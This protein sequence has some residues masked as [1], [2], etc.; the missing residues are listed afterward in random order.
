VALCVRNERG[1][2]DGCNRRAPCTISE[3]VPEPIKE[4]MGGG[5]ESIQSKP[6][7]FYGTIA[8]SA[9]VFTFRS[10]EPAPPTRLVAVR[11]E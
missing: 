8:A 10:F 6:G 1:D 3:T 11:I 2:R 9:D 4:I 5:S 7:R